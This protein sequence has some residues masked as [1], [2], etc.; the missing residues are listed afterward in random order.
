MIKNITVVL[1]GLFIWSF[2]GGFDW[3]FDSYSCYNEE[4]F[5]HNLMLLLKQEIMINEFNLINDNLLEIA[6]DELIE[7]ISF[8]WDGKGDY[9]DSINYN[10][11]EKKY[12]VEK[13]AI[14][15]EK[16]LQI[17]DVYKKYE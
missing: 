13:A 12:G 1:G 11:L 10:K 17:E 15:Y 9:I 6:Q 4:I 7:T 3:V 5:K 8:K 16:M 2:V 14:I